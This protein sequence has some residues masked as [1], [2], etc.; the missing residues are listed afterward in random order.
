MKQ[1]LE[2]AIQ[3]IPICPKSSDNFSKTMLCSHSWENVTHARQLRVDEPLR[4]MH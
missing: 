4:K 2:N 1:D 3:N